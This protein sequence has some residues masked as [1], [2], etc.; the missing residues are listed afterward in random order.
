MYLRV[1]GHDGHP[2]VQSAP[3]GSHLRDPWLDGD[4]SGGLQVSP[5]VPEGGRSMNRDCN[6]PVNPATDLYLDLMK[7]CLTRIVFRESGPPIHPPLA[8]FDPDA[9]AAGM[10]WPADG[11]TMIGLDRLNNIQHCVV[12]VLQR[13]VPGDLI[14]AGVWRG[15]ATIFMR[16]ILKAYGETQRAVWVADSFQG[17][18]RADLENYPQD[19]RFERRDLEQ[20][21]VPLE[22]VQANFVRYGLLDDQVKFLKGWFKDTLPTAPIERLAV[23]RL[24]ADMYE[25]TMDALTAL[26]PRLSIGGYVILDD[27][28]L[29]PACHQA[30]EDYRGR[31]GITEPVVT[32]DWNGAYWQRE[33]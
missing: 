8:N 11:E 2:R 24:D 19:K 22:D 1:N 13:G 4:G 16:A 23:M 10:D 15:G 32:I 27:Y 21:A 14:E 5:F 33:R 3:A 26:Y 30:V 12:D 25:S 18:P 20:L 7:K 31:F 6:V 28:N 29:I 9:R 17:L